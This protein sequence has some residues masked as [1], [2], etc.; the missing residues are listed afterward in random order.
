MIEF[1]IYLGIQVCIYGILA[2]SLNLQLGFT[3]LVNFGQV[4][5]LLIGAYTSALITSAGLPLIVGF[6]GGV[7]VAGVAGLMISFTTRNLSGTYWA[8]ATLGFAELARIFA[9]NETEFTGGALGIRGIQP[10]PFSPFLITFICL[11]AVYIISELIVNSPFGRVMK[12]IREDE[13]LV[14]SVGK[15][16]FKVKMQALVL[17]SMIGGLS[18]VLYAHYFSY[19]D[20]MAFMPIETFIVWAM[21]ILGGVAN[22]LGVILGTIIIQFIYMGFRFLPTGFMS[23]TRAGS[24]RMILIGLAIVLVIM[25]RKKGLLGE[26]TKEYSID[27]IE[28]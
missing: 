28:T 9:L 15:S 13:D 1:F 7:V 20:P 16:V 17:S 5:F 12:T 26:K 11:V 8:I 23:G 24:F 4:L 14:E 10:L 19:I 22:N 27:K 3:R 2:L 6:L 25:F 21:V 18:G